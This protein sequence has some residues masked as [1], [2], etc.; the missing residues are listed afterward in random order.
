MSTIHARRAGRRRRA[1]RLQ[2]KN[3]C[4]CG[5]PMDRVGSRCHRCTD[6]NALLCRGKYR[7]NGY[8]SG[9]TMNLIQV[10]QALAQRGMR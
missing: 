1:Y 2:A 10:S 6:R 5:K 8:G 3:L 4:R 9:W 7:R